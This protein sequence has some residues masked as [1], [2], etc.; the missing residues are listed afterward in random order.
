[1]NFKDYC[2]NVLNETADDVL[3]IKAKQEAKQRGLQHQ[4]H[5][6]WKDQNGNE[7]KW[8][9]QLKRFENIDKQANDFLKEVYLGNVTISSSLKLSV[10]KSTK[11]TEDGAPKKVK[12]VY[13]LNPGHYNILIKRVGNY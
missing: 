7:F 12:G 10:D 11:I 13:V 1:M 2:E 5:N 9:S 4:S 8:N 6:V 3:S